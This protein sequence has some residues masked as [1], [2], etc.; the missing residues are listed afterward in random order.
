MTLADLMKTAGYATGLFGKWHLGALDPRYHPNSRGFDEFAGFRG[1]WSDYWQWRLDRNRTFAKADG[2][3]LTDV[4][5]E[6]AVGFIDRHRAEPFFL[7]VTYNAPHFPFQ[8]PDEELEPF[9]D[10]D[11]TQG[12]RTIYA[13][14]RRMDKGVGRILETLDRHCLAEN[15]LVIFTSDNGPQFGG[16][17]E[18]DTTRYNACFNGCKGLVYEGGIRVPAV[19]RWPVGLA[20]G[21]CVGEMVHFTDW[22]PTLASVAGVRIPDDCELDGRDALPVIRGEAASIVGPRFWQWNRYSPVGTCNAAMRDGQ[23]KLIR[24]LFPEPMRL[25]REDLDMDRRLKYEGESITDICRDPEPPRVIPDP[26][27]A[28][29]YDLGSDPYEQ[30]DLAVERP[31]ILSRMQAALDEWF[32]SVERDRLSIK[33]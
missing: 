20:A 19:L 2:R 12:V 10:L 25:T 15:T 5:T 16:D 17:G 9:A 29:L 26:P 8:V 27:P 14:N 32:G 28:Q 24:P 31:E 11:V 3:Y 23:W 7:H 33:D 18:T 6:E 4:I 1:G 13:M 30:R 22:L 21:A